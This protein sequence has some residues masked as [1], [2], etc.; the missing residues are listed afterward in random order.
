MVW[1]WASLKKRRRNNIQEGIVARVQSEKVHCGQRL[2]V[3][4][5]VPAL[6]F[7]FPSRFFHIFSPLM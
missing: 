1:E 4:A 5:R 6:L 3:F 2:I 7:T